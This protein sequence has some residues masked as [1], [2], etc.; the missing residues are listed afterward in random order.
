MRIKTD[1]IL[2]D[3]SG[4]DMTSNIT[5]PAIWLSH[6]ANYAI[7]LVFTGAPNGTFK[8][9]ASVD[10]PSKVNPAATVPTNWTDI[11]ASSQAITASGDHMWQVENAG[12]T[13]VRLVWT[14]SASGVS[15]VTSCR[16]MVKGA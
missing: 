13:F 5:G 4:T 11:S 10:E 6:I 12:Y 2:G 1:N 15:T 14:D 16:F 8:L 7:Q 9:Q 3:L